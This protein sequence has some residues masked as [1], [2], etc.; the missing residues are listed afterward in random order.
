MEEEVT[1]QKFKE[2]YFQ[3]ATPSSGW[4][5]DYWNEFFEMKEGAR[6]FFTPPDT[7]ESTRMFIISGDNKY[8]MVFL[9]EEAEESF[10]KKNVLHLRARHSNPNNP[11]MG[12]KPNL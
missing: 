4:T 5:S 8:R 11:L 12:K 9:T 10:F 1:K 2:L 3:Y 6:Y 7:P